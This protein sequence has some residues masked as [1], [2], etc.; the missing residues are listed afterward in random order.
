MCIECIESDIEYKR[1]YRRKKGVLGLCHDCKNPIVEGKKVCARHEKI[2]REKRERYYLEKKAE[3]L[4][5]QCGENKPV[6]GRTQCAKCRDEAIRTK[7]KRFFHYRITK[8]N[9]TF[10]TNLVAKEAAFLWKRQKG[11]CALTGRKL[12]KENAELD[13]IIPK[14]K[15]GPHDISNLRWLVKEVNRIKRNMLD[16]A[17][18]KLCFDVISFKKREK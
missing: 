7:K 16:D 14:S 15:G 2:H 6:E 5:T 1:E 3:G 17:F 18:M 8:F 12:T 4:C 10:K 9:C 13:H 11:V